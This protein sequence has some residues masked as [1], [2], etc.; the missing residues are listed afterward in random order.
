MSVPPGYRAASMLG[1]GLTTEE[2]L[3]LEKEVARS[4]DRWRNSIQRFLVSAGATAGD[5]EEMTQESF[6]RLF[7]ALHSGEQIDNAHAWLFRVA[8]NLFIDRWRRTVPLSLHSPEVSSEVEEK[9]DPHPS[10]ED[11]FLSHERAAQVQRALATLTSVQRNCLNLRAEGFRLREIAEI[12]GMSLS[13]VADAVR[14]GL[15][16]LARESHE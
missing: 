15:T 4:F 3:S 8:H 14:R 1:L 11:L 5:A 12:L 6:F 13:S 7:R 16:R 10:P 9:P 2:P